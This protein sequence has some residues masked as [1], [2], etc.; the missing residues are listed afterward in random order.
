M[1][2][3]NLKQKLDLLIESGA[4]AD[5]VE[6]EEIR[7]DGQIERVF[8]GEIEGALQ[9]STTAKYRD[10]EFIIGWTPYGLTVSLLPQAQGAFKN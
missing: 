7:P 9:Y 5:L 8:V 2:F 4:I 3:M 10:R 1:K 6:I